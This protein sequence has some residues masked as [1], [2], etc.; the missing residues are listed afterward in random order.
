M[1]EFWLDE[2]LLVLMRE[3]LEGDRSLIDSVPRAGEYGLCGGVTP[4]GEPT[5]RNSWVWA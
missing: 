1:R 4:A 2:E 3:P 5:A